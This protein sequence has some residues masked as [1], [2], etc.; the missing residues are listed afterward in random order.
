MADWKDSE[1]YRAV[2]SYRVALQKREDRAIGLLRR[3]M[4][5]PKR[6]IAKKLSELTKAISDLEKTGQT[7]PEQMNALRSRFDDLMRQS[8]AMLEELALAAEEITA[9]GQ[10]A[11]VAMTGG[12]LHLA[13]TAAGDKPAGASIEWNV[14]PKHALESFV[15][16]ASD[17]SPLS[18]LFTTVAKDHAEEMRQ[19]I[20]AGIATGENPRVVAR[21]LTATV[22]GSYAR[23]ETICRTEMLRAHREA[24][25]QTYEANADV[26]TGYTR[27]CA[28]DSRVCSACFALH[29]T[30]SES[31]EVMASHANCRCTMAPNTQDWG[32]LL[33][34]GY[35]DLPDTRPT[36]PT[37]DEMFA[38]LTDEEKLSV[39]GPG[40]FALWKDGTVALSAMA[41]TSVDPKWGPTVRVATLAELQA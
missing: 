13:E 34:P 12:V 40:K 27:V 29:G 19:E 22:S 26:V 17:G 38:A 23:M 18:H 15:G 24:A 30:V 6:K 9:N 41:V 33:G 28:G 1:L 7:V 25:R 39:L 3:T 20:A 32:S 4:N 37:N 31:S 11:T 8:E 10:A 14:L 5:G 35:E 36:I 16:F 2:T 21:T